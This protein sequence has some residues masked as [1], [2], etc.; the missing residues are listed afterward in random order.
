MKLYSPLDWYW[1]VAD[2]SE[3]AYSS[4]ACNYVALDDAEYVAWGEDG[5]RPNIIDTEF[6]LGGVLAPYLD[7][8]PIP[9]GVLD[10]YT[11]GR[12][13]MLK[14]QP[15]YNLWVDS[16]ADNPARLKEVI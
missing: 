16:Y 13:E 11:S 6:N 3:R 2:D 12:L 4:K 14:S 10:G 7:L 8:R 15:D 5:T 9:Q 1:I